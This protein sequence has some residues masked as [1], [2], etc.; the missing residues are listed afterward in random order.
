M[1]IPALQVSFL[2]NPEVNNCVNGQLVSGPTFFHLT[3]TDASRIKPDVAETI[4]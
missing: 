1:T 4:S 2:K 3:P